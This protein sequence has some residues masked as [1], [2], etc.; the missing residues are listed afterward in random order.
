MIEPISPEAYLAIAASAQK[1]VT[2]YKDKRR[3]KH[4]EKLRKLQSNSTS[5]GWTTTT[6]DASSASSTSSLE[7]SL[8]QNGLVLGQDG[9][10]QWSM[11]SPDHPRNWSTGRKT[12]DLGLIIFLDFF[13]TAI[14]AAGTPASSYALA[15]FHVGKAIGILG[16]TTMYELGAL[17]RYK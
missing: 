1:V 13:T 6:T 2:K 16:F 9:Y 12:Y 15:D 3:Y 17:W 4:N 10:V 11:S 7:E 8:D 14:S 5:T